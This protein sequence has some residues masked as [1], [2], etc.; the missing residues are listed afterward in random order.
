MTP[1]TLENI[2]AKC[3]YHK[4]H[5]VIFTVALVKGMI[6]YLDELS[7]PKPIDKIDMSPDSPEGYEL[8]STIEHLRTKNLSLTA[9]NAALKLKLRRSFD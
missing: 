1:S 3:A 4:D 2:R 5:E 7:K 8:I 6:S 9:E